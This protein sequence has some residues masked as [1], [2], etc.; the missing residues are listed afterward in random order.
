MLKSQPGQE[1]KDGLTMEV[2]D[3]REPLPKNR[4]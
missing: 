1:N 3:E 4:T 2:Y